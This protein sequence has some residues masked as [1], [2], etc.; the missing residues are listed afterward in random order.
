MWKIAPVYASDITLTFT[1]FNTDVEDVLKVYDASNNQLL[2]EISGE[3]TP[4]NMPAPIFTESGEIFL[5]FQSDG[6]YNA[7]G[8]SADWEIG[9]VS[10]KEQMDGVSMLNVFPNPANNVLNVSF[11]TD[12]VQSFTVKLMSVTGEVV[13]ED[14]SDNFSGNYSNSIDVSSFAKGV[15]ILNLSNETGSVNKKVVIR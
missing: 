9:N 8:W 1:E 12:R 15:Y 11:K 6:I 5:I 13:Y 4:G 10:V 7:P 2:A 3:Y 14:T